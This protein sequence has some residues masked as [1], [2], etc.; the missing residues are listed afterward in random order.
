MSSNFNRN[1]IYARHAV[2]PGYLQEIVFHTTILLIG[3]GGLGSLIALLL[4]RKGIGTLL[5]SDPDRISVSNLSRQ[6]FSLSDVG[7]NKAECAA[8]RLKDHCVGGTQLIG[9]PLS[10]QELS[11]NPMILPSFDVM[12]CAVDNK[13]A[14][15]AALSAGLRAN[16]PVL[17]VAVDYTAESFSVSIQEPGNACFGCMDLDLDSER[18]APCEI[19]AAIDINSMAAGLTGY[20]LD[21]LLMNTRPVSWNHRRIHAAGFMP[22]VSLNV[23]KNP[24][25]KF[26]G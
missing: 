22:D 12:I 1:E 16:R 19:P 11:E 18:V 26:C 25:C 17:F 13:S 15:R 14:R 21:H 7:K 20:A 5:L 23:A 8:V 9:S 4:A 10:I 24:D 6:L 3:V 2:I